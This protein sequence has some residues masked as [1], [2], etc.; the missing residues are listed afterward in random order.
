M[1][2]VVDGAAGSLAIEPATAAKLPLAS[3]TAAIACNLS[4]ALTVNRA[5]LDTTSTELF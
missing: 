3:S 2:K 1:L 4:P 5:V